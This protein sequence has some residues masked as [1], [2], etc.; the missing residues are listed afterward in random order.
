MPSAEEMKRE[1]TL[2]IMDTHLAS[3][4]RKKLNNYCEDNGWT[5]ALIMDHCGT[6][7]VYLTSNHT[8]VIINLLHEV[9]ELMQPSRGKGKETTT[10]KDLTNRRVHIW[11]TLSDVKG[12]TTD[13]VLAEVISAV[14]RV[15]KL[16]NCMINLNE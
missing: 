2:I 12:N 11:L 13:E 4:K 10:S 14:E 9:A 3:S 7:G 6:A 15:R 16:S 5:D 1:P 8:R